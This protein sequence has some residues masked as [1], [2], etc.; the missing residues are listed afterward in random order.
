[1]VKRIGALAAAALMIAALVVVYFF[2]TTR[3]AREIAIASGAFSLAAATLCGLTWRR[4]ILIRIGRMGL[5]FR[6][7]RLVTG[8]AAAIAL[9][10]PTLWIAGGWRDA[11]NPAR[12]RAETSLPQTLTVAI[13]KFDGDKDDQTRSRLIAEIRRLTAKLPLTLKPVN[14]KIGFDAKDSSPNWLDHQQAVNQ[15]EADKANLILWGRV[16]SSPQGQRIL[17]FDTGALDG[18]G[19]G[20]VMDPRDYALPRLSGSDL[21]PIV[22]LLLTTQLRVSWLRDAPNVRAEL[23]KSIASV[24]AIAEA[25]RTGSRWSDDDRANVD[26]ILA[27]AV[28]LGDE[29]FVLEMSLRLSNIYALSAIANWS[30]AKYPIQR[31]MA[32][33]FLARNATYLGALARNPH[34]FQ[35]ESKL[36]REALALYPS[37]RYADDRLRTQIALGQSLRNAAFLDG[38]KEL[39]QAMDADQAALASVDRRTDP[40]KWA[41]V[42]WEIANVEL[43]AGETR[44]DVAQLRAAI[45]SFN[46]ALSVYTRASAP[47]QWARTQTRLGEALLDLG[48]NDPAS[49]YFGEAV[50][51]EKSALEVLTPAQDPSFW[52]LA[53]AYKGMALQ[54]T[55]NGPDGVTILQNA[56]AELRAARSDALYKVDPYAWVRVQSALASTLASLGD[57]ELFPD[58]SAS[59]YQRA[60]LSHEDF[61]EAVAAA[62]AGIGEAQRLKMK[63]QLAFLQS[64]LASALIGIA[65][66]E[67]TY[68]RDAA[69]ADHLREAAAAAK[70]ALAIQTPDKNGESWADTEAMF[71]EA[72]S[73]LGRIDRN[74]SELQ[75]AI[76]AY[77]ASMRLQTRDR[78]PQNWSADENGMAT[79]L[80]NLGL[81]GSGAESLTYLGQAAAIQRELLAG[82]N[83]E[84]DSGNWY[85]SETNLARIETEMGDR[86]PDGADLRLA[87]ADYRELLRH[88][89]P[90]ASPGTWRD[91]NQQLGA[92][93]AEM[94][95][96]G[97]AG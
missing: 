62:R 88:V 1:M 91:L 44:G 66:E 40:E 41:E 75:A 3:S 86:E 51:A 60:R 34:Y 96:R 8:L 19:F 68:N 24:R 76:A 10:L 70:A 17:L 56:V 48:Y 29:P 55:A 69:A 13:A 46:Q 20:G 4:A 39:A 14:A 32:L 18:S 47:Q 7:V 23:Q 87:A 36:L 21:A 73:R 54:A 15:E 83:P 37:G 11:Y 77:Q 28:V 74:P 82:A 45:E 6:A 80:E 31:A 79:A 61:E 78:D 49:G 35:I 67:T 16:E 26:F 92:V 43:R 33:R 12:F 30:R 89:S 59:E 27:V 58:P 95:R 22:A 72:M 71:A 52:S 53:H 42:E 38:G 64:A 5:R 93:I 90:A 84:T 50:A 25:N 63:D 97:V 9:I 65:N 2:P 94:R 57:S 85:V 81:L